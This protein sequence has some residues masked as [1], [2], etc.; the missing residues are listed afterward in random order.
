MWRTWLKTI[1]PFL[2]TWAR[3][4]Q[5][6]LAWAAIIGVAAGGIT[7]ALKNSVVLL[8]SG[9]MG[10]ESWSG[11]EG[12]IAL[13]P[14]LGLVAT[15]W[16]VQKGARGD[17]P[18]PG[19]PA[20]LHALSRRQGRLKRRWMYSPLVASWLTV[21]LGGSG[22]LEAPALQASAAFG[23]EVASATKRNFNRRVLLIA[24]AAAAS[25][26]ATFK[27]PVAAIIFAVEVIMIDLTA[28]SLV[29]LLLASL[30]SL[31]TAWFLLEGEDV[32]TA[33]ELTDFAVHRL[34]L[35]GLLGLLAGAG[36]VLFSRLYLWASMRMRN[37]ARL[38]VRI[39]VAGALMGGAVWLFP[40]LYGEGYE[41]INGLFEGESTGLA[42]D[43]AIHLFAPRG[44]LL[45]AVLLLAWALKPILTGFTVGAGGVAGVF[46]PVLFSGAV[47]GFVFA[48][49]VNLLVGSEWM[50]VGNAVLAGLAGMLAGVLHAPLTAVF[51]A[52]EVSGGYE[53]F[54]PVM[55]TAALSFQLARR[56]LKHSIYTKELAESGDL[57]SHNKDQAVL[58]LM[59]LK[60]EVE[61]DF[62]A[63]APE[64][65][66]G[67]LVRIIAQSTRNLHPVLDENGELLGIIDLQDI[68]QIM[69]DREQYETLTVQSLMAAPLATLDVR[70][71]MEDVMAHFERT[72]AWNLPVVSEG[73]YIGFVSRSR[74]FNAYRRWLRETH[75]D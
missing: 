34:P 29:P 52:A 49:S 11:W 16:F 36:S 27:A 74:L 62:V 6:L 53:L 30:S 38:P 14:I 3:S 26:A 5:S 56:W 66:L 40:S 15:A 44:V 63:V 48:L 51:L 75:Q 54:V 58:T 33:P 4:E 31:L 35:Y 50:P 70:A 57:L 69:F 1:Q 39:V 12:A 59:T 25:L 65:T 23:S 67:D 7:V 71:R 68:R 47:L 46:A 10:V 43:M 72:K 41:V 37:V 60:E 32:L 17:H 13:G 61:N 20:T 9:L 8:R 42:D 45:V 24:C 64:A 21:G 2:N 18:G 19:V 73:K 28:G 55:L 22:G